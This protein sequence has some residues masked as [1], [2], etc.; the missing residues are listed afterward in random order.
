MAVTFV[1]AE[2]V[3][4]NESDIS[5]LV[6]AF[7]FVRLIP[8]GIQETT[9]TGVEN[10]LGFISSDSSWQ[11]LLLGRQF[12]VARISTNPTGTDLGEFAV[13][14]QQANIMLQWVLNRFQRN[15]HRLAALREGYLAEKSEDEL[16]TT[17]QRLLNFS[18]TYR[19]NP[20]NEWDW[21]LSALVNREFGGLQEVTNTITTIKRINAFI[22][23]ASSPVTTAPSRF[24]RIRVDLDINTSQHNTAA[25]FRSEHISAFF[26][27]VI[28]WHDELRNEISHL[29]GE[30]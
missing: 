23:S 1:D 12:Q 24:T 21:R 30:G 17:A 4:P 8:T 6:G 2:S 18:D 19:N 10:R 27:R 11:L 28:I 15:P 20:L 13:F 9:S 14:C 5:Q 7:D 25:R 3:L 16:N 26:E 29:I 22:S